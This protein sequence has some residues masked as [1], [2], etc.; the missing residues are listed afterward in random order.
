MR[1]WSMIILPLCLLLGA[2]A[3]EDRDTSAPASAAAPV[4]H[5]PPAAEVLT[6][7]DEHAHH[8]DASAGMALQRPPGGGRWATDAPLRQGMETIH[9][10][11]EV[12]IPTFEKGEMTDSAATKLAAVVTGQVQFL[13]ANCQLEPDADAQLHILIGQMLSAA[14]AMAA[15]AG[16]AEGVPQLH[17]AVQLYGDYFEHPGLHDHSAPHHADHETDP[18]GG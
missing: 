7:A 18:S 11:L 2:C 17:A 8:H 10:A 5:A 3:P 14:E 15:D 16:S 9:A 1:N 12:A 6:S 4:T 13:V